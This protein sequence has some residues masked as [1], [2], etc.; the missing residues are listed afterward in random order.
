MTV[1]GGVKRDDK[2]EN[3]LGYLEGSAP[4]RW[5]PGAGGAGDTH[6]PRTHWKLPGHVAGYSAGLCHLLLITERCA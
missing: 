5:A 4:A 6:R 1:G 3:K 2:R